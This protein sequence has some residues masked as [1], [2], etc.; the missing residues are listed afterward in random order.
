M[1]ELLGFVQLYQAGEGVVASE[2]RQLGLL[3]IGGV[4][5][6]WLAMKFLL[7]KRRWQRRAQRL[8]MQ[9]VAETAR[10]HRAHQ[11]FMEGAKVKG[12]GEPQE[13]KPPLPA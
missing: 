10:R 6:M 2:A 4:A 8:S 7:L 9:G 13:A 12:R 1:L 3:G 5:D 11:V